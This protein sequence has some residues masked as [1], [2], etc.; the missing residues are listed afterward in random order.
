[1]QNQTYQP[2]KIV[3]NNLNSDPWTLLDP[4]D[5]SK[6]QDRPM[7]VGKTYKIPTLNDPR[8]IDILLN[9]ENNEQTT[10]ENKRKQTLTS[11]NKISKSDYQFKGLAFPEFGYL[12]KM[13]RSRKLAIKRHARLNHSDRNNNLN[14]LNNNDND[15]L[16]YDDD[17]HVN[18]YGGMDFGVYGEGGDDDDD[19]NENDGFLPNP[20]AML[21]QFEEAQ[22]G[23]GEAFNEQEHNDAHFEDGINQLQLDNAFD[24]APKSYSELCREHIAKY[25]QGVDRYA[26]ESQL[27]MRVGEWQTR[28]SPMLKEQDSRRPFDI[29]E[30]GREIIRKCV[31]VTKDR[32]N[33]MVSNS[34]GVPTI[35]PKEPIDFHKMT[36][37]KPQFEICRLFLASLQLSN[38]LNVKLHHGDGVCGPDDLKLEVLNITVGEDK[39]NMY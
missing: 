25:M 6:L 27:S 26:H 18:D 4:H 35:N 36:A 14:H 2:D 21:S 20:N 19:D 30:Y 7:K 1:M 31:D 24:E 22:G 28:L 13:D 9:N 10:K 3:V 11:S 8:Q 23:N 34:K 5:N 16:D 33:Q 32:N 38:N 29:H 37:E 39:F 12:L 15:D 17:N